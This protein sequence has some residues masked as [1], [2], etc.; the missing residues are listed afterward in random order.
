MHLQLC[1]VSHDLGHQAADNATACIRRSLA[2][3]SVAE[4]DTLMLL[5]LVR[6]MNL[7]LTGN[8]AIDEETIQGT[9]L[10]EKVHAWTPRG[11]LHPI[12]P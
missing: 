9:V 4:S 10:G 1:Q 5:W 7:R 2:E 8:G 12:L 6:K 11:G 3:C